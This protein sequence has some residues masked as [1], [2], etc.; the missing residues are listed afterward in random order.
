M[1]FFGGLLEPGEVKIHSVKISPDRSKAF[2]ECFSA[3]DV[4]S[5]LN[6]YNSERARNSGRF[7]YQDC[8]LHLEPLPNQANTEQSPVPIVTDQIL[9]SQNQSQTPNLVQNQQARS[10]WP[11]LFERAGGNYRL[12]P[13]SGWFYEDKSGFYYD[14]NSKVLCILCHI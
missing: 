14:Y 5:L 12:D 1:S 3:A 11:T 4:V 10:A 6:V 8:Q 2:V 13:S 9:T 7:V